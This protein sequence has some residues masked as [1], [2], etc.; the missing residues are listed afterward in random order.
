MNASGRPHIH[1][2]ANRLTNC[3]IARR[4]NSRA[5]AKMLVSFKIQQLFGHGLPERKKNFQ[6]QNYLFDIKFLHSHKWEKFA[7]LGVWWSKQ[8][9]K[10]R[11]FFRLLFRFLAVEYRHS[12]IFN[13]NSEHIFVLYKYI[14]Y[15]YVFYQFATRLSTIASAYARTFV[16]FLSYS[17]ENSAT[18]WNIRL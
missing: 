1:E 8:Q 7:A 4:E 14:L 17:S 12:D 11:S 16:F 18:E 9:V 6:P 15:Y 13:A 3:T 2:C 5:S 10:W